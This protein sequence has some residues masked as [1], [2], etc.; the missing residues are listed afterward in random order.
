MLKPLTDEEIQ[1]TKL[2]IKSY[3][4]DIDRRSVFLDTIAID[5]LLYYEFEVFAYQHKPQHL[6]KVTLIRQSIAN[7]SLKPGWIRSSSSNSASESKAFEYVLINP[8]TTYYA[9]RPITD[10]T[11]ACIEGYAEGSKLLCKLRM[12]VRTHRE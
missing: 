3:L 9:Y 4:A 8:C 7:S 12:L 6:V 11:A 5:G 1:Q 2:E 10:N